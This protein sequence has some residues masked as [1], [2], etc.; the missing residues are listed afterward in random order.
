[1]LHRRVLLFSGKLCY[2]VLYE[3]LNGRKKLFIAYEKKNFYDDIN[4]NGRTLC[5]LW[6]GGNE[7]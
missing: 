5:W 2:I 1:M 3:T 4:I 6:Q 7:R